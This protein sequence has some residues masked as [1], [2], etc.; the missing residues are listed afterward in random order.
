MI[1]KSGRKFSL[2]GMRVLGWSSPTLSS[3]SSEMIQ[4]ATCDIFHYTG[5][6]ERI[7]KLNICRNGNF[8]MR[9]GACVCVEGTHFLM[10]N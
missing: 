10:V 9:C 4:Q 7:N 3:S 2:R 8:A 6:V 5:F 1:A